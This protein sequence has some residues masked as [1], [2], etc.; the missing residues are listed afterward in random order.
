MYNIT[1]I[2]GGFQ[3]QEYMYQFNPVDGQYYLAIS[4]EQL[5]VY[6]DQGIILLDLSCTINGKSYDDI[7]LFGQELTN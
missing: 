7:I 2:S 3:H 6:T 4:Q 5:H 1:K